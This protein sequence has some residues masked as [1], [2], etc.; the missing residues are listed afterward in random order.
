LY[1]ILQFAFRTLQFAIYCGF[2]CKLQSENCK[3]QIVDKT[4]ESLIVP[5]LFAAIF[6]LVACGSFTDRLL[7]QEPASDAELAAKIGRLV[8]Q[9]DDDSYDVRERAEKDLVAIGEAARD[10]VK[11]AASGTSAEAKQRAARILRVLGPAGVGLVSLEIVKRDDLRGACGISLSPDGKFLYVAAWR[12]NTIATFRRDERAGKIEHVQSLTDPERLNGVTCVCVSPDGKWALAV[13]FNS[14]K[15]TLLTRDAEKGTLAFA[16]AIGPDLVE[17]AKFVWPTNGVFSP[18]SKHVYVVDDQSGA[19]VA[20][21]ITAEGKLSWLQV[22]Q[23][24][25]GCF[26]GARSLAFLPDGKTLV[27]GGSKANTLCLLDRDADSGRVEVR[28]VIKDGEGQATALAGIHGIA[29][30]SDGRFIYTSAGRFTGD[31]AVSAFRL[32]DDGNLAAIHEFVS[33][34]SELVDFRGGNSATVSPDG[35]SVYACGTVS[36]S[37]ACFQR[38]PATGE[39]TF[40]ATLRSDATG[41]GGDTGPANVALSADSRFLYL[42]LEGD[43]AVSAFERKVKKSE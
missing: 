37:L 14:K 42:T 3:I 36:R 30:T 10:A 25:D 1:S 13:A 11:K 15:A 23:G 41:P 35:L 28:Q 27:V 24:R 32:G 4:R 20:L 21:E 31:Q 6:V 12:T 7:A 18:D 17:G 9:L 19:V 40:A 2:H 39:L 43:G 29:A 33:D 22:S 38:N 34:K 26:A 16:D 8:T 5:K